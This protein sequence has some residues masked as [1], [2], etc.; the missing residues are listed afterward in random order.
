MTRDLTKNKLCGRPKC[1][2]CPHN[3]SKG[4]CKTE[5]ITYQIACNRTPCNQNIP[6]PPLAPSNLQIG[7]PPVLYRG[8][9]SR[10]G[11][12]RSVGHLKDYR[13][14]SDGS[15][16]WRH[17]RDN[18]Y[19]TFGD[20][21]GCQDY[22]MEKI[23]NLPKALDRLAFE[24]QIIQELEDLQTQNKAI[25]LNSKLDFRQSHSVTLNFSSGANNIY[26]SWTNQKVSTCFVNFMF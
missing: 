1:L 4:Q 22:K 12:L 25:C 14:K 21:R 15:S 10:T 5:S 8:E 19:G 7:P 16:L 18:H 9:T 26:S 23:N 3:G 20:D 2:I 17:T 24:G 13:A 6:S 11:Y